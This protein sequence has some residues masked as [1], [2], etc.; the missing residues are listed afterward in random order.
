MLKLIICVTQLPK[1]LSVYFIV[2]SHHK[3]CWFKC[4]QYI[5]SSWL[6]VLHKFQ[7]FFL[8]ILLYNLTTQCADLSVSNVLKLLISRSWWTGIQSLPMELDIRKSTIRSLTPF[9]DIKFSFIWPKS[10]P[11]FVWAPLGTFYDIIS[12]KNLL[13]SVVRSA[14]FMTN[15]NQKVC[16]FKC[17]HIAHATF[18]HDL[19]VC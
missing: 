19:P 15:I 14:Y 3:V 13:Q 6:F 17:E 12:P 5:C 18:R 11:L 16:C 9:N 4:E 2:E 7:S 10:V 1:L 8:Y